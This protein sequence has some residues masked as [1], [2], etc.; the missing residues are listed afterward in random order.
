METHEKIIGMRNLAIEGIT[1]AFIVAMNMATWQVATASASPSAAQEGSGTTDG[2]GGDD[3][4]SDDIYVVRQVT[5]DEATAIVDAS[6]AINEG[7][8]EGMRDDM[9]VV[10]EEEQQDE[11]DESTATGEVVGDGSFDALIASAYSVGPEVPLQNGWGCSGWVYLVFKNAG[12]SSFS[13]AAKD[14]FNT[15]CYSSDLDDLR[16][17]MVISVAHHS[18]TSAGRVYGHVG[19]YIGDNTVRHLSGG[20]VRE[21]PLDQWISTYGTDMAPQWGWNGGIALS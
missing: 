3:I 20:A 18:L 17:G 19:I 7:V 14:F 8:P 13:G 2:T 15:W 6:I 12:I 11:A 1:M 21:M 9:R 16:P 10:S 5:L 4:E